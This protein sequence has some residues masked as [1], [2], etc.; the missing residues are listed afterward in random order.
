MLEGR[1]MGSTAMAS[2]R[3]WGGINEHAM[4]ARGQAP[5]TPSGVACSSRSR[6]MGSVESACERRMETWLSTVKHGRRRRAAVVEV[7][8]VVLR[9]CIPQCGCVQV[10]CIAADLSE[11]PILPEQVVKCSACYSKKG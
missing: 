7:I 6:I 9:G 3:K 1:G 2:R 4:L 8:G 5:G 10:V 11:A